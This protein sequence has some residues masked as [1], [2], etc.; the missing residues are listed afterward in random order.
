MESKNRQSVTVQATVN[1]PVEKAWKYFNEP[2]HIKQW[3]FASDDWHAPKSENDLRTGGKFS[4]TMAAKDGSYSFEFGGV[5][6]N[7]VPNKVI[8]YTMGDG[9]KVK[10]IFD[11]KNGGTVVTQ[12][13]D[14][15]TENPID[16]QRA[17]WQAILDNFKKHAEKNN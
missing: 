2:D 13:F 10:T 6:D 8:E 3:A 1:T 4:T 9:R 12:T 5:Y 15:E 14:A 7:V 17:G 16:M 11:G